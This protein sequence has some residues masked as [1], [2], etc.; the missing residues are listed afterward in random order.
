MITSEQLDT[1]PNVYGRG[2]P[3]PEQLSLA[4]THIAD[5]MRLNRDEVDESRGLAEQIYGLAEA[6]GVVSSYAWEIYPSLRSWLSYPRI[7]AELPGER[8]LEVSTMTGGMSLA[9]YTARTRYNE[10][11][12][13]QVGI[14]DA[15]QIEALLDQPDSAQ[16]RSAGYA[17]ESF[18]PRQHISEE[19][20]PFYQPVRLSFMPTVSRNG[21]NVRRTSTSAS[22][23]LGVTQDLLGHLNRS[24]AKAAQKAA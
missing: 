16:W 18:R 13:R 10:G 12:L 20:M 9:L 19:F 11:R 21:G 1:L 22:G 3:S 2:A 4:Q 5:V 8:L 17:A 23:Y 6:V 24:V 14:P 15:S 7:K